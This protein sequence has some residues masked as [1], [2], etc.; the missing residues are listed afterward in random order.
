MR[1]KKLKTV[2]K[3]SAVNT[4][5]KALTC[6]DQKKVRKEYIKKC[7]RTMKDLE[8]A[9][10]EILNYEN[11]DLP[12]YNK[13]YH[14]TFGNK[15]SLI[16]ETHE[17]AAEIYHTLMEIEYYKNKKKISY[18][19]AYLIVEDKKK[20]PEK[21]KNEEEKE[22]EYYEYTEEDDWED[23]DYGFYEDSRFETE[24]DTD[25]EL[26]KEI[27]EQFEIFLKNN[28]SARNAAQNPKIRKFFYESFR[29]FYKAN[30]TDFYENYT[31]PKP[32][33][34]EFE[35]RLKVKYREL[36]RKLHPDYIKERTPHLDNLWHEVQKA[37]KAQDLERLEML[38]ALTSIQEGDFSSD[39]SISQILN[40]QNE[41]KQQLKAIRS[42]IREAKK[43]P[44]WGFSKLTS[45]KVIQKKIERE[46]DES[47]REEKRNLEH[48]QELLKIWSTPPDNKPKPTKNLIQINKEEEL[49]LFL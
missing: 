39:F 11:I 26:E 30:R 38:L 12:I 17:K 8:K 28:P 33:K 31:Q 34:N 32:N 43:Q 18:Y 47:Y 15:L 16:R 7:K 42:K 9:K 20:N 3:T 13:W 1:L 41:Y 27:N 29:K 2:S 4:E 35:I 46:L 6:I 23:E 40:V 21:Y 36:V 48:F 10:Q 49:F 44:A 37:Y 5:V 19:E 45:T 24:E 14:S 22:H 25:P